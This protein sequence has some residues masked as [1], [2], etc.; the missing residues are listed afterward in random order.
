MLKEIL[1]VSGKPGLYKLISKGSNMTIIE[2]LLDQKR[3]PVYMRDKV[4]S[5]GEIFIYTTEGEASLSEI[6]TSIKEKEEGKNVSIDLTKAGQDELRAYLA[7]LLPNFD[8]ERVYPSDIK[9]LLKWYDLLITNGITDFSV[10]KEET[11][12]EEVE[13]ENE[14]SEDE[15][16]AQ[17]STATTN[18]PLAAKSASAS[19]PTKRKDI[20]MTSVKS[21]KTP[22]PKPMG[23]IPKKSIVGSKRGS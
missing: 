17:K 12:V 4:V 15:K 2:S 23:A 8:R 20:S 18:T 9:K 21:A 5:L 3:I 19:A 10:K 16:E 14:P 6:L 1:S 13:E 11:D 22:K 7:E